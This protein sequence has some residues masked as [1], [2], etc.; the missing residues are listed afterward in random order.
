MSNTPPNSSRDEM[1]QMGEIICRSRDWRWVAIWA[2]DIHRLLRPRL[3]AR[4]VWDDLDALIRAEWDWHLGRDL[5]HRIRQLTLAHEKD[6]PD[7]AELAYLRLG[8][9]AAKCIS[10]ASWSPGLFDYSVP[11]QVPALALE[12]AGHR[13]DDKQM[14]FLRHHFISLA[15]N[16]YSDR[17]KVDGNQ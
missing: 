1:I 15:E 12:V 16:R 4:K 9:V 8:E 17:P 14:D 3:K 5:F 7:S 6:E 13:G 11:W 2:Y 10:N